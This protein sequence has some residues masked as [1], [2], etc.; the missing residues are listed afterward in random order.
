MRNLRLALFF[1]MALLCSTVL[2]YEGRRADSV[3]L[4]GEWQFAEGAATK[5]P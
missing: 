2:A 1:L 4:N 5:T 3:L